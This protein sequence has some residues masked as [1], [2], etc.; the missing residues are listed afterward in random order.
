MGMTVVSIHTTAADGLDA[1]AKLRPD[2]ALID[3][4]LPDR[5]GL[6]LGADILAILPGTKVVALTALEDERSVQ[7]ALRLGFDGYFTKHMEGEQFKR[8]L[9]SVIDGQT[10][11]PHRLGRRTITVGVEQRDMELMAAQLTKREREVLQLLAEGASSPQI[12]ARLGVSPNTVRTHVQG[13]L[14]K[15]QLHSRL[16]A[17]AFAVRF[18]LVKA[19]S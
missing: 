8:S 4:G 13:I 3:L 16:E 12:A 9:A 17:A 11:Y 1:A 10:V 18:D 7:E 19:R 6:A 5:N 2:L 15:L 14:S